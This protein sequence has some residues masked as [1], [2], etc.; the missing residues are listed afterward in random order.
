MCFISCN[1]VASSV[2]SAPLH[3]SHASTSTSTS[4]SYTYT[5]YTGHTFPAAFPLSPCDLQR[6]RLLLHRLIARLRVLPPAIS[7]E[8]LASSRFSPQRSGSSR[9]LTDWHEP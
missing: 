5:S 7:I 9:T 6:R 1:L 4:N 2:S 8:S 3:P